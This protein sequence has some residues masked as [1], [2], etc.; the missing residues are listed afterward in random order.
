M[1]PSYCA[2]YGERCV[3][4]RG[5]GDAGILRERGGAGRA[6]RSTTRA[7]APLDEPMRQWT[8]CSPQLHHA[9]T[10]RTMMEPGVVF[11]GGV[12]TGRPAVPPGGLGGTSRHLGLDFAIAFFFEPVRVVHRFCFTYRLARIGGEV[13][14]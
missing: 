13:G 9:S 6:G 11:R 7:T 1:N 8:I 3:G 4:R 2:E 5:H 10:G 12:R 14:R